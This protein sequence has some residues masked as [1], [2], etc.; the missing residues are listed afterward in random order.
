MGDCCSL[1]NLKLRLEMR[2][3]KSVLLGPDTFNASSILGVEQ[4][5]MRR[6]LA[7]TRLGFWLRGDTPRSPDRW[8]ERPARPIVSCLQQ[9]SQYRAWRSFGESPYHLPLRITSLELSAVHLITA[10]LR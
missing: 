8:S 4:N 5:P 1:M 2:G 3:V 9:P 7:W 6:G 10:N